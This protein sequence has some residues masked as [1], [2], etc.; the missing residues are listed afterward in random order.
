MILFFREC[1]EE[2]LQPHVIDEVTAKWL[3]A[4]S[5]KWTRL[6]EFL[7]QKDVK[8]LNLS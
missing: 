5:E 1:K 7:P 2:T 6:N 8:P 3:W 4:V